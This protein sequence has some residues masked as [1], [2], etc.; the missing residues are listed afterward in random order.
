MLGKTK[1]TTRMLTIVMLALVGM[2]LVGAIGLNNLR[3]NLLQDRYQKTQELVQ[4]AQSIIHTYYDR[5]KAGEMSEAD[6]KAAALAHV[7]MLRYQGDNYFWVND[8]DGVLLMHPF[9]AKQ[10][11]TNMIGAKTADG[12][13]Y[14]DIHGVSLYKA[15]ADAGKAGGDFVR[16]TG[17]KPGSTKEDSPKITYVGSFAPWR[18]A[19]ATGIYVDDVDE[20]FASNL[21]TMAVW[22]GAVL[23]IVC[24]AAWRI[25]R[26]ITDPLEVLTDEMGR[27][28]GG[29]TDIAVA[30]TTAKNEIGALTNALVTFR[31]NAVEMQAMRDE[32]A[33]AD[34]VVREQKRQALQEMASRIEDEAHKAVGAVSARAS[35]M[36]KAAVDMNAS[37]ARMTEEAANAAA[38]AEEA[39]SNAQTVAAAAE[40]LSNSIDEI[41]RQVHKSSEVAAEAISMAD[42]TREVVQGL[43]ASAEQIGTVV[44]L[45]NGIAAQ[46]NLLALNATI[47]AARAG[48][49]GKGFAVVANEVKNLATQ[50]ARST[51]EIANQVNAIQG[52]SK[53]AGLAIEKVA[54]TINS[55][56]AIAASIA[57][58][59]EEQAAATQE[60]ARNV[61]QTADTARDV[62]KR[63][64]H[65][66]DEAARTTDLADLVRGTAGGLAVNLEDMENHLTTIVRASTEHA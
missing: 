36:E 49:A 17:R 42:R 47:E 3:S 9:R 8:F 7:S 5:F 43:A 23:L 63:M 29:D 54:E 40:E 33:R 32:Q 44:E 4:A 11:G 28:A 48:D 46:T 26:S 61:Q 38:A 51:E 66:S 35:E 21:K 2:V 19:I 6:A 56:G 34:E 1:I 55:M 45:I 53:E 18:M 16:Y 59:I 15:F 37:A 12:K 31:D 20:V 62:S 14:T 25:G 41:G 24:L 10:V 52:V 50:T 60:I 39:L 13:L 58:A 27:L 30:A 65:V 64:A 22:I 57:S